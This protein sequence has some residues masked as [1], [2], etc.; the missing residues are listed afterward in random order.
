MVETEQGYGIIFELA[1][2]RLLGSYI[3]EHPDE[4]E[5]FAQKFADLIR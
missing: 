1:G 3:T 4:L 2:G 5:V